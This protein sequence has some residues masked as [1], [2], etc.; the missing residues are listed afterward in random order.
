MTSTVLPTPGVLKHGIAQE[1]TNGNSICRAL[2]RRN[3]L[4]VQL[5]GRPRVRVSEEFLRRLQVDAFL[6]EHRAEA[7]AKR[8][9]PDALVNS[10]LLQR[11]TNVQPKRHIRCD[12]M[13]AVVLD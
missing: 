3:G 6:T 1:T 9:P 11:W 13:T 2:F 10:Q 7:V 8:M 4:L 5:H 12:R